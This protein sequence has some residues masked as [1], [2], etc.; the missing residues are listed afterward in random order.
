METKDQKDCDRGSV[1]SGGVLAGLKP[2][3]TLPS[4]L[5][6]PPSFLPSFFF[7][8]LSFIL[9]LFF[10]LHPGLFTKASHNL[11]GDGISLGLWGA[12]QC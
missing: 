7:F 5:P 8:F 10:F 6:F 11:G 12:P 3:V 9:L 2:D 4:F 1:K